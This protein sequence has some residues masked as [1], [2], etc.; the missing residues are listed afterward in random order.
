[1]ILDLFICKQLGRCRRSLMNLG[2]HT[3]LASLPHG[4]VY[5]LTCESGGT[6]EGRKTKSKLVWP[7]PRADQEYKMPSIILFCRL[8]LEIAWFLILFHFMENSSF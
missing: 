4:L 8:D 5:R 2:V 6:C 1:M 7:L 3:G